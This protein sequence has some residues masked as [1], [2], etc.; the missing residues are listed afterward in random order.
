MLT[1]S[2]VEDQKLWIL[3][4][5]LLSLSKKRPLFPSSILCHRSDNHQFSLEVLRSKHCDF[6]SIQIK[7]GYLIGGFFYWLVKF[8]KCFIISF[9]IF[10]VCCWCLLRLG[11]YKH[12]IYHL[13]RVVVGSKVQRKKL[14]V[15]NTASS[16]SLL[17]RCSENKQYCSAEC[18]FRLW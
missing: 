4:L 16:F 13:I 14:N 15:L 1:S 3:M 11:T 12:I 9:C 2:I 18:L 17:L 6:L 8:S 7:W 10:F 5:K